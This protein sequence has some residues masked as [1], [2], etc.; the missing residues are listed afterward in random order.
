M[1][2]IFIMSQGNAG[3]ADLKRI[4]VSP[5]SISVITSKDTFMKSNKKAQGEED[6]PPKKKRYWR[7][8]TA[9]VLFVPLYVLSIGPAVRV[10]IETNLLTQT[11]IDKIYKPLDTLSDASPFIENFLNGYIALWLP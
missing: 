1:I 2:E 6:A 9:L 7:C 10:G 11:M 4:F 3:Y 8:F 5:C